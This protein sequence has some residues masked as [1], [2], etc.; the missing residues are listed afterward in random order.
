MA[1]DQQQLS[2][3]RKS[4]EAVPALAVRGVHLRKSLHVV[5]M[6]WMVGVVWMSAISG[7]H[8][9][10][11]A[12]MLGFNNFAF[13]LLG[14]LPFVATFGQLAAALLI[15]RTGLLKYQFMQCATVHR[16][17]WLV[18]AAIPLVLPFPSTL[19]VA[20]VLVVLTASWFMGALSSPAW[21]T[22]MGALVPRRI[23]GRYFAAR[24]RICMGVQIVVVIGLGV[25]MDSIVD[26]AVTA[27][28]KAVSPVV[29]WTISAILA[30]AALFGTMD[31]LL[32]HRVP[33]VL[34]P[35]PAGQPAAGRPIRRTPVELFRYFLLGPLKD[36]AFRNYVLYG[37]TMTF[38]ITVGGWF[39][40]RNA[41]ENLGFSSLATNVLFLVIG[42]IAGIGAVGKWGKAIDRWGRRPVL[43]I[44][45]VG[46]SLSLLGWFFASRDLPSPQ[47]V[48]HSAA[49]VLGGVGRLFG[50]PDWAPIGPHT[51]VTAYLIAA[52]MCLLGGATWTGIDLAQTGIVLGFSDGSGQ[53]RYV[54]ASSVLISTGGVLG[55]LVG[56]TVAQVFSGLE[57]DPIR[58][59]P[60]LWNNW[61]ATFA[62]AL[63]VRGLTVWFLVKMPDPGAASVLSLARHMGLN[64]YNSVVS[65][66]FYSLRVFGWQ[67]G[68]AQPPQGPEEQPPRRN[69][70]HRQ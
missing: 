24:A 43:V 18:V 61:H 4:Y 35:P 51:P 8:F 62:L 3:K 63:L 1:Y 7:S 56:G 29:M 11:F 26:P 21:L 44:C 16:L 14:T 13:G 49:W 52:A 34:P 67:Q 55:G 25:L 23:R 50:H 12:S 58:W 6:A 32:F 41:M 2:W 57:A 20:A 69:G 70:N 39:F 27:Q 28:G 40:W 9:K 68:G 36:P 31:I 47:F 30:G 65:R 46:A 42:P 33:E 53:S 66:L 38:S 48:T 5:T 54:A 45:T 10:I 17:L 64:V 59:G 19:A 15:E 22:W 37:M 60:F